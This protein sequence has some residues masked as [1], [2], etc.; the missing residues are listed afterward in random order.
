MI[1]RWWRNR[2]R[3]KILARGFPA[4]WEGILRDNVRQYSVLPDEE[5]QHL[6]A[7]TQILVGEKYWEGCNGLQ[8]TD[9]IRVTIAGQASLLLLG[10]SP[11]DFNRL[12]TILVYPDT[13]LVSEKTQLPGG[14]V[15]EST[16]A[17]WGEAWHRGPVIISW[18]NVNR[19]DQPGEPGRN[20]VLH[21]FAHVLDM[22]SNMVNGTPILDS[23]QQYREW[24]EVMTEEFLAL[25]QAAEGNVATILDVYGAQNEAEFFAVATESFFEQPLEL[26]EQHPRLYGVLQEYYRQDPVLWWN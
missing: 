21:E 14:V 26:K 20:L 8:L 10:S 4:D 3:R 6:R 17:R 2:R 24:R 13:Y 23:N 22:S 11:D 19:H 12:M 16:G 1:A 18:S 9:E 5:R 7:C 25:R 15:T